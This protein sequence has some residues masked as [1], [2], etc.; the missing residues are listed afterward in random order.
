M[1]RHCRDAQIQAAV[2]GL[3]GSLQVGHTKGH[4]CCVLIN[5]FALYKKELR[6]SMLL[7]LYV[8]VKNASVLV[9]IMLD[10]LLV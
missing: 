2:W 9:I 5:L 3:V 6:K 8:M 10:E 1:L 4:I 7:A